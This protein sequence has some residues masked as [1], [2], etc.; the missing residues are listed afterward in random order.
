MQ[1]Q[2][3]SWGNSQGVRL[4]KEALAEAGFNIDDTL[5]I[6]FTKGQII[7]QKPFHHRSLLDRMEA[8]EG[9]LYSEAEIDF[10]EKAEG[11]LW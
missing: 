2:L 7:L 9:K 3:K 1:T 4:P 11:E 5:S 8:Y 6:S 10:G